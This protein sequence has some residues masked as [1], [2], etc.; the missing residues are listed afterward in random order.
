MRK[1]ILIALVGVGLQASAAV[2]GD[3]KVKIH[4]LLGSI[5]DELQMTAAKDDEL[6]QVIDLL[7]ESRRILRAG[8]VGKRP[9]V[10][11][12]SRDQDGREP[13]VMV[14][15][16]PEDFSEIRIPNSVLTKA[17]CNEA[18][19]QVRQIEDNLFFCASRDSDSRSP[20]T[21]FVYDGKKSISIGMF[22]SLESCFRVTQA[23][24]A[25]RTH[26]TTCVSRDGDG[27]PPFSRVVINLEN[28]E[29]K[30]TGSTFSSITDCFASL[31]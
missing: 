4:Q 1:W 28:K 10:I 13:Y 16:D 18:V 23:M 15:Y 7:R 12:S 19:Q 9:K 26:A 31:N 21:L 17:S 25:S 3:P 8:S 6:A 14:A 27:R 2:T 29:V 5:K 24:R 30:K 11:C 22:D 20:F